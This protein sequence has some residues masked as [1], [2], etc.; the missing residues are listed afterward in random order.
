MLC[1]FH[2]EH[3]SLL[4]NNFQ[5]T[6]IS[7]DLIESICRPNICPGALICASPLRTVSSTS[8]EARSAEARTTSIHL[9]VTLPVAPLSAVVNSSDIGMVPRISHSHY[10]HTHRTGTHIIWCHCHTYSLAYSGFSFESFNFA[11]INTD[12][13]AI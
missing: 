5:I 9:R 7:V 11:W 8:L 6:N 2:F 4:Q 10:H 12:C 13:G 1:L 3:G